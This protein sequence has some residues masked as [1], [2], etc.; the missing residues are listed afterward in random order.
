MNAN[1]VLAGVSQARLTTAQQ[2]A[3]P[4]RLQLRSF[5]SQAPFTLFAS[6]GG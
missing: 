3:A 5:R 6:G 1:G 4:D 2:G